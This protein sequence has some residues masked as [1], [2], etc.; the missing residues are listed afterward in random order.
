MHAELGLR[1][2]HALL[3]LA[4]S[5]DPI[6]AE[7]TTSECARSCAP[8]T[9]EGLCATD[10]EC[11][12]VFLTGAQSGLQKVPCARKPSALGSP[13]WLRVCGTALAP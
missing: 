1:P 7:I 2:R 13:P 12:D 4:A 9:T 6:V 5:Q 10:A 11:A 8:P 3:H